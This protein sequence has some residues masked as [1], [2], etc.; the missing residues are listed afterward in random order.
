[1]VNLLILLILLILQPS[2]HRGVT[3]PVELATE[4]DQRRGE[5]R[6]DWHTP[7]DCS[8]LLSVQFDINKL[9]QRLDDGNARMDAIEKTIDV[10]FKVSS[11]D[12][13]AIKA[14]MREN[15]AKADADREQIMQ[16]QKVASEAL[17]E[18]LEFIESTKT[19]FHTVTAI[20]K[21]S[22]RIIMWFFPA[23]TAVI[24]FIN[25]YQTFSP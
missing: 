5:R 9:V 10:N 6:A 17:K 13:E 11:D 19:V 21:W 3:M 2:K 1:L 14:L 25:A 24:V 4:N 15:Y 7:D 8:K 18:P 23:A 12:R 16:H 22:R 20:G